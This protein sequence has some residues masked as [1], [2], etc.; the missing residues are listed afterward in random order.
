MSGTQQKMLQGAP[1]GAQ[2]VAVYVEA[3]VAGN[4]AA[5][6]AKK[7]GEDADK[8]G[9]S[10]DKAKKGTTIKLSMS[11]MRI[12]HLKSFSIFVTAQIAS[13]KLTSVCRT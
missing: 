10:D 13:K 11:P 1:T 6:P 7:E 9:E 4:D 2:T 8:K 5:S 3:Q 12:V